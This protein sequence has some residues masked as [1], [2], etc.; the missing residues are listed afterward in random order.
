M[1]RKRVGHPN[2]GERGSSAG[3]GTGRAASRAGSASSARQPQG[4]SAARSPQRQAPTSVDE[5][6]LARRLARHV[7]GPVRFD[8]MARALCSTDAS[9]YEV[10]PLGVVLPKSLDDVEA[11]LEVAREEGAP[12]L[13][14]GAG[15]S[16]CGQ[17]VGRAVVVDCSRH[18]DRICE[19]DVKRRQAV[20]EPG[21]VLD[22]LNRRLAPSGLFFPV[23]VATAS[24]ATI[25]GMA[26][27]NSGGARSIRYGMTADNV[28]AVEASLAQ[29]GVATFGPGGRAA[30]GEAIAARVQ[31]IAQRE[32]PELRRRVPRVPRHVAGYNLHR[33]LRPGAST[34]ELLVGSE[35]TLAFFRR[36]TLKLARQPR[37]RALGICGFPS[38]R[39]A[40]DAVQHVV[41]LRPHAVELV[42]D[43]VLRLA[44]DNAEF[45]SAVEEFAPDGARAVLLVEFAGN[46]AGPLRGKLDALEEA[47][48]AGRRGCTL[49]RAESVAAQDAVWKV[50]RTAMN[51]VMSAKGPRRQVSIVEDCAVPLPRLAEYAEAVEDVFARHGTQGTWYA[52]ASVGCLHV[53]PSLDVRDAADLAALR[54]IAEETHE[55][56]RRLGGSHSG[57]HGDGILRS[58]FIEPMLGSRLARA[59]ADVKRAF[60]PSGL[61]NP[62]K[63]VDPPRMDDAALLRLGPA[64]ASLPLARHGGG[65]SGGMDWT[66]TG[67][68]AAALERCNNNGACRKTRSGVMC[69]SFRVTREERDVTRGRANIL[70]LAM[71]G[72]LGPEGLGAPEVMDAL[73]LCVACKACKRECPVG[74]DMARMKA[75]ALYRRRQT[76]GRRDGAR[77]EIR[78]RLFAGLPRYAPAAARARRLLNLRNRSPWLARAGERLLGIS[79]GRALPKWSARPFRD[80]E[81]AAA[82]DAPVVP[83]RPAAVL[84]VD[85]F[86]R[87]FEPEVAR[88]GAATLRRLGVEPLGASQ[89]GPPLCCGRTWISAGLLDQARAALARTVDVLAPLAATGLPILG[90]EPSCLLTLREDAPLLVPGEEARVVAGRAVLFDEHLA[91]SDSFAERPPLVHFASGRRGRGVARVHGHC[92]QKAAGTA[93]ATLRVVER[94]AGLQAVATPSTCCGMAGSFGYEAEHASISRSMGE[95]DLLP[96]VRAAAAHD[97]IVANGFSCRSQIRDLTGR[98]AHHVATLLAGRMAGRNPWAQ[99]PRNGQPKAG[100]APGCTGP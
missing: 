12:V 70:R 33:L 71:S 32:A 72:A 89:E 19:I 57:E 52:H 27:N 3:D 11:V 94:F 58:E 37:R 69:P 47:V 63:I 18:L 39:G 64:R 73:E 68:F 88:A 59:F 42:D 45:R 24:R 13:P 7:E 77:A 14:R 10:F 28:L 86:H 78:Q 49:S 62:G 96:A 76:R 15:T 93:G 74:V 38:L 65:A 40:L 25:G 9:I 98:T 41:E 21:V 97:V 29:G 17:T 30:G 82:G 80:A 31:E 26:G 48:G 20:V 54:A 83:E 84:F 16:Q 100:P 92:H 46:E 8:A 35:G 6:R 75:E 56:V 4:R 60:D 61:M 34:A 87:Y 91:A 67:G 90:L 23:D 51:V 44:R 1:G 43:A 36:I 2:G 85:T 66:D 95:L 79:A 81:L 50:R 53:R 55:V 5:S 99:A 22:A